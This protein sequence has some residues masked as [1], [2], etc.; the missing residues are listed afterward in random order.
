[1]PA[2]YYDWI[3]RQAMRRP[4]KLAIVDLGD[5][6]RFSYR[7]L[8][9]RIARVAGHLA[10]LGV[11][12]GARVATLL[13]N[14]A[15]CLEIQFACG[16]LG[17]IFVPLNWRLTVPELTFIVND[18]GPL[19]IVHDADLAAHAAV[20][21]ERCHVPA[22]LG[23][24]GQGSAYEVAAASASPLATHEPM[25]LDDT[26]TL[27]YT[28][29]TT[30][31]P[32]GAIITHGMTFWNAVNLNGPAG[33]TPETV[34]LC[35]LPLFQTAGLNCYSNPVLHAG[36]TV[37]IAPRFDPTEI[38][39]W[40]GRRELG[41]TLFIGVPSQYLILSQHPEFN[42]TDFGK[43]R[44]TVGA[45][46]MPVPLLERYAAR[47]VVLAQGYGMTETSPTVLF[48]EYEDGIRK[49]GSAGKPVVHTQ[50][51]LVRPDGTDAAP[52]EIAELWV[53]GPNVTP[54]YWNRPDDN[55][56]SFSD[57]WLHTGDAARVD[58]E[59]YYYIVD[60]WK[61]MYISGGEN[62]Y[63]AEVESV[64]YQLP[65]VA[66]TA[67][68]GVPH[69][70]WGEIG[71]AMIVLRQGRTLTEAE[72]I[73]HCRANLAAYKIPHIVSFTDALPKNATGKVLKRLL[74]EILGIL[75]R[76]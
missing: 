7:D 14:C 63:P 32:K 59:G 46:P 64:L 1:M 41:V 25:S 19:V 49:A 65:A 51:R 57:G 40:L 39:S 12:R 47:G 53:K 72:V 50:V 11:T 21:A 55:R 45:A 28:S 56:A 67:V 18:S 31:Q 58:D 5:G 3:A 22:L 13:H 24:D 52:G 42:S 20:V 70:R 10:A 34:F 15:A 23:A 75:E 76:P 26:S 60:R 16:R 61:D 37:L 8:D 38:L 36:G 74:R 66:E 4:D 30:G 35:T 68:L 69:E 48:L 71:R 43:V 73:A 17:A 29:G 27:M 9:G 44:A 2:P 54:G 62:V 33:I 6:R